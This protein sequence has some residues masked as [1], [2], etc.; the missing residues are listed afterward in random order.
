MSFYFEYYRS[1]EIVIE[2][3]RQNTPALFIYHIYF[4]IV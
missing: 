4:S 1:E 3:K 2:R